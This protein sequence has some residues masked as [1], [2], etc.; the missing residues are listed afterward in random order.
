MTA[1]DEKQEIGPVPYHYARLA[2]DD[3]GD[4]LM[5][6]S[7]DHKTDQAEDFE[8]RFAKLERWTGDRF[9]FVGEITDRWSGQVMEPVDGVAYIGRNP[10]DKNVYVI[11]G[12]SGNG[13][14]HGILAGML[15]VDLIARRENPWSNLYDPA[16]KTFKPRVLADYIAENANVAA[17]LRDHV[18]PGTAKSIDEIK[19]GEGAVL[20]DGI[21]KIATYRD[22]KGKLHAFSAVCPHF[23]CVVR[24]DACEKTWDCPCHMSRFDALGHFGSYC[25]PVPV[26]ICSTKRASIGGNGGF[27]RIFWRLFTEKLLP[28]DIFDYALLRPERLH[29]LLFSF[30][31]LRSTF[32]KMSAYQLSE[33]FSSAQGRSH[34]PCSCLIRC[35]PKARTN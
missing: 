11:T 12:D 21:K 14:T 15:I 20:H 28:N 9:P 4:V 22:E 30:C 31:V 23:K 24:W 19:R 35:N 8:Q 6:G 26:G 25:Q 34:F 2:R 17:Q 3:Q 29:H 16:R 32:Q 10:G 18:T 7:E 33:T 13:I 5:V 27:N 1:E